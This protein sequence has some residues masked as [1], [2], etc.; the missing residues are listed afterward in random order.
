MLELSQFPY[1]T[2]QTILHEQ[3]FVTRFF[4]LPLGLVYS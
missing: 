3:T 4:A 1:Y 2:R